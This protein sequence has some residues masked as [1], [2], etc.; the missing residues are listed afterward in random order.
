VSGSGPRSKIVA[1]FL[2]GIFPGL[3]QLYNREPVKAVAFVVGSGA[4]TWL[5]A[6]GLSPDLLQEALR[7]GENPFGASVMVPTGLLTIVWIWSLIDAWRV[8]GR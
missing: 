1:L 3:G 2:S 7:Q 4:L 5:A 8:A 6:R